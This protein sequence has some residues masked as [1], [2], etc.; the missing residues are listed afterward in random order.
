MSC[1]NV[2]SVGYIYVIDKIKKKQKNTVEMDW[3]TVYHC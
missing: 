3:T 2:F 1:W